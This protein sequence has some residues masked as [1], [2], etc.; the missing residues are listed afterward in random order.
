VGRINSSRPFSFFLPGTGRVETYP[1]LQERRVYGGFEKVTF[2]VSPSIFEY[3]A[4]SS[5]I[6]LDPKQVLSDLYRFTPPIDPRDIIAPLLDY[7]EGIISFSIK[8]G[9]YYLAQFMREH[10]D[11][12]FTGKYLTCSCHPGEEFPIY[13]SALP[14]Y[15][16]DE[17]EYEDG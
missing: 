1:S 5:N 16:F 15:L 9:H 8:R 7:E 13:L 3:L 6:G 17:E 12:C 11:P 14:S 10:K 4:R 2:K